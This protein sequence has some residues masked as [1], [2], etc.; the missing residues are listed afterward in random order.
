MDA[1]ILLLD[2]PAAGLSSEERKSLV[3]LLRFLRD[4]LHNT[5]VFV[6]H[7]LNL[8]WRVADRISVLDAGALVADGAPDAIVANPRVRALFT[9]KQDA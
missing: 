5:I 3:L 1:R 9:G 8:V 6:E 2:E 7:D 4:R